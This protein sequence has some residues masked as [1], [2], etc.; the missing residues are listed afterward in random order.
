MELVRTGSQTDSDIGMCV[1]DMCYDQQRDV[2]WSV[3][4]KERFLR[5][6][7]MDLG[8]FHQTNLRLSNPR[9]IA[10][11]EDELYLSDRY[12]IGVGRQS[13][14]DNSL[15]RIDSNTCRMQLVEDKGGS[16]D[17]FVKHEGSFY[18]LTG[19][20][21][22]EAVYRRT[23][24]D[25]TRFLC[26]V[27]GNKI[28]ALGT[29]EKKLIIAR[30]EHDR[31]TVKDHHGTELAETEHPIKKFDTLQDNIVAVDEKG[32]IYAWDKDFK[33][34]ATYMHDSGEMWFDYTITTSPDKLYFAMTSGPIVELEL[35]D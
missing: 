18:I 4:N 3:A 11:I 34:L 32:T 28:T 13:A 14:S 20:C 33:L 26:S 15:F 25:L 2:I 1:I 6:W 31:F 35:R 21:A 23:D 9:G 10:S 17:Y 27:P 16:L 30:Q 19:G 8:E 5:F 12:D 7:H 24:H 22:P 29:A